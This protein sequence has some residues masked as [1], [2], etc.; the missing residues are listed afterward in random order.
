MSAAAVDTGITAAKLVALLE[1]RYQAP[2]WRTERELTLANQRL[3][4][5][6]FCVWGGG[7]RRYRVLGFEI[8]VSRADWLRELKA[9]EKAKH[10][11]S[12]VDEFYVVAPAGIVP[13]DELPRGWGLL[14]VRGQG[15]LRLKAHPAP[16]TPADT[17]P[18][19][20]V[21]RLL[22]RDRRRADPSY[23]AE[24]QRARETAAQSARAE[25]ES[26]LESLREAANEHRRLLNV[27]GLR[28]SDP[29]RVLRDAAAI[30][31]AWHSLPTDWDFARVVESAR[32][33]VEKSAKAIQG[34]QE[35]IDV[36]QRAKALAVPTPEQDPHA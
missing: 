29:E 31:K 23:T 27:T 8:K 1:S 3:D 18:R 36:L 12:V 14:E 10:W 19:E 26:E 24:L 35:S 32:N 15:S 20:L 25:V 11:A 7:G 4:F 30:E 13:I 21:A 5:V 6:A 16:A 22:D 28:H 17:L 33:L 2:E 34:L 9:I